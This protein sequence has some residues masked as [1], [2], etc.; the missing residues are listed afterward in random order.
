VANR[1][2]G[3]RRYAERIYD[4]LVELVEQGRRERQMEGPALKVA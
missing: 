2:L 4:C 1:E 3:A